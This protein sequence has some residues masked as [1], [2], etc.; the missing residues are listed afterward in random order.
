MTS[1]RTRSRAAGNGD[2]KSTG[3]LNKVL[4]ACVSREKRQGKRG[5][6]EHF[7]TT[8]GAAGT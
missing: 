3:G 4:L 6:T 2:N 1:E 5:V 7:L 8:G